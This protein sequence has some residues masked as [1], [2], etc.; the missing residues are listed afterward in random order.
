MDKNWELE[1]KWW[2]DHCL[3]LVR[4]IKE[5]TALFSDR[6]SEESNWQKILRSWCKFGFCLKVFENFLEEKV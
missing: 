5:P 3:S 2:L 4:K 6:Q 1:S